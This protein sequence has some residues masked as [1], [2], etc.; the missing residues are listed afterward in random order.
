MSDIAIEEKDFKDS[1]VEANSPYG[2]LEVPIV[3]P[4]EEKELRGDNLR[5][6]SEE[7]VER[8]IISGSTPME[9]YMDNNPRE[10]N[11]K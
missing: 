5:E 3:S 1:E 8:F 10:F 9:D 11:N 6:E 4:E 7:D 2:G